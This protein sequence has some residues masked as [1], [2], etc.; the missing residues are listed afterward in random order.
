MLESLK[1][2]IEFFEWSSGQKIN[3]EKSKLCGLNIKE[4]ELFEEASK[5]N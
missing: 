4:S 1:K 5:L 2:R 3:W